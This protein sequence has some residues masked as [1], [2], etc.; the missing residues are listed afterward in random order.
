MEM[1]TVLKA[2]LCQL[3]EVAGG[4]GHAVQEDLHREGS[5]RSLKGCRR[6]GRGRQ[7]I[8][9]RRGKRLGRWNDTTGSYYLLQRVCV[10]PTMA[11]V[12][13]IKR[14]PC[15]ANSGDLV[16]QAST[17]SPKSDRLQ[18]PLSLCIGAWCR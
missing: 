5:D 15:A 17:V 9:H 1:Q 11:S 12:L 16:P 7:C 4:Q 6:I 3:D 13:P 8:I 2:R 18:L 14:S 10:P